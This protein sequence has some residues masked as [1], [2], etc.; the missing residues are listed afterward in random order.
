MLTH[1]PKT[2]PISK[3]GKFY[4]IMALEPFYALTGMG[5]VPPAVQI[6]DCFSHFCPVH[7]VVQEICTAALGIPPLRPLFTR[8]PFLLIRQSIWVTE[9]L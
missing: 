1:L 7:H 9:S 8:G 4:C 6:C 3:A 5:G 2:A